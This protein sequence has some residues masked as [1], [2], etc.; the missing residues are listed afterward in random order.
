MFVVLV[1]DAHLAAEKSNEVGHRKCADVVLI[2]IEYNK[3]AALLAI[4]LC[5]GLEGVAFAVDGQFGGTRLEERTQ[6]I[7]GPFVRIEGVKVIDVH[8]TYE[9]L[10][11]WID[12]RIEVVRFFFD[13]LLEKLL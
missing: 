11:V 9:R 7:S 6:R 13:V 2:S 10:C 5:D 3:T 4:H 1:L 8:A 12:D